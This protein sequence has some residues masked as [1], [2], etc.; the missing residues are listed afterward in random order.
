MESVENY[1][2]DL[3]QTL[4]E[5]DLSGLNKVIEVFADA[6]Q[7]GRSIFI[8]GNG[9]SAAS[10]S[11]FVCDVVKG[12][13]YGKDSR[14]RILSL[15]DNFMTLT[16]YAND[17][18]Y[19]AVFVEPL[20]NFAQAGDVFMA[21]SGS[22]NSPNVVKAMEYAQQAGLT[23]IAMTGRTGGTLGNLAEHHLHV[24]NSH[25]GRIEDVH[26]MMC[27]MIAYHFMETEA[28]APKG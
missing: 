25:M 23:T 2:R 4:A 9:G 7:Q 5:L 18:G 3:L 20:K 14:F 24:K 16:A 10:A 6:R 12:A 15:N 27:H 19:D 22:G 26:M 8:A 1:R 11:H 21:I 28:G 17:V 13:S